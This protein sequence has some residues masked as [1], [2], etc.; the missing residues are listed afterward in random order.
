MMIYLKLR[1]PRIDLHSK[2][3]CIITKKPIRCQ[4][5]RRSAITRSVNDPII[6]I[7]VIIVVVVVLL[8]LRAELL[9]TLL[10]IVRVSTADPIQQKRAARRELNGNVPTSSTY[11]N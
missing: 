11:E 3:H 9:L 8:I 5:V 1:A 10:L 7:I 4:F 2:R 6:I